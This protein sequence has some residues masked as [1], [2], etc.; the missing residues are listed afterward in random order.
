MGPIHR[1]FP[2]T[3]TARRALSLL[4]PLLSAC[5]GER[6][7]LEPPRGIRVSGDT[8][9]ERSPPALVPLAD[10]RAIVL[11]FAALDTTSEDPSEWGEALWARHLTATGMPEGQPQ[12]VISEPS[13]GWHNL[14]W[15]NLSAALVNDE[16][17]ATWDVHS[18]DCL[19]HCLFLSVHVLRIHLDLTTAAP[20]TS[21]SGSGPDG[22]GIRPGGAALV[23]LDGGGWAVAYH[24]YDRWTGACA[25]SHL[26]L[27]RFAPDGSPGELL[28]VAEASSDQATVDLYPVVVRSRSGLTVLW[29]RYS[30]LLDDDGLG[31]VHLRQLTLEGAPRSEARRLPARVRLATLRASASPGDDAITLSGFGPSGELEVWR[32]V[33]DEL[34]PIRLI[35]DDSG[36]PDSPGSLLSAEDGSTLIAFTVSPTDPDAPAAVFTARIDYTSGSKVLPSLALLLGGRSAWY[37]PILAHLPQGGTAIATRVERAPSHEAGTQGLALDHL[38]WYTVEVLLH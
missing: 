17:V 37:P 34:R 11:W 35:T 12:V 2:V 18:P 22:S 29:S 15:A 7:A 5:A 10:G 16:V 4:I 30:E 8:Q 27:Q 21:L 25:G 23:T 6:L 24:R 9:V 38:P 19:G 3:T 28:P 20:V 32:W 31:D 26:C 33:E 36:A 14:V 13:Q 1:R